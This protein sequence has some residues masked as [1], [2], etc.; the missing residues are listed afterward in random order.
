MAPGKEVGASEMSFQK[1]RFHGEVLRAEI[2]ARQNIHIEA[3]RRR[4]PN[5][6]SCLTPIKGKPREKF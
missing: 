1:A 5:L 6:D 2:N 3:I 4:C